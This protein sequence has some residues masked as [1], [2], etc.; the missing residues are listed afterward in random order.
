[1]KKGMVASAAVQVILLD[2][3][4]CLGPHDQ[5]CVA[6]IEVWVLPVG[7]PVPALPLVLLTTQQSPVCMHPGR[8]LLSVLTGFKS[9]SADK[10]T[11]MT[12]YMWNIASSKS[13]QLFQEQSGSVEFGGQSLLLL[14]REN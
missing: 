4:L 11:C 1:M 6:V 3:C 2:F 14:V 10:G 8:M 7:L 12:G 9:L 13:C 5:A